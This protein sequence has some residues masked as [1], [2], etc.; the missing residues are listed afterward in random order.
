VANKKNIPTFS[1]K[2]HI[3]SVFPELHWLDLEHCISL[4]HKKQKLTRICSWR[5]PYYTWMSL[6][7]PRQW[8][9]V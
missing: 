7:L 5:I 2:R 3:W 9:C 8:L 4:I 6:T 1:L